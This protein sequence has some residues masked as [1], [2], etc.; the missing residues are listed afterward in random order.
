[1]SASNRDGRAEKKVRA[2]VAL[3]TPPLWEERLAAL[4]TELKAKL[5]GAAFRW[6]HPKQLH[7][8]LRFFGW[9]T[10]DETEQIKQLLPKFCARRTF[11]LVSDGIGCF[12]K[13]RRP[14]VLWAGLSGELAAAVEL[15]AALTDG[16]RSFGEPPEVRPFK[17][18]LTL[19]RLREMPRSDLANVE[20]A[21]RRGFRIESPW[22]VEELLLMQSHLSAQGSCYEVI[23]R[24]AL[25]E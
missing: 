4:Q 13:A 19:A 9:I 24:C 3:K 23:E 22:R 12:P 25:G 7:I 21:I 10:S 18:H 8:T 20:E 2:F 17:P 14:R 15:Q 1:M 11:E 16:T 5:K 6:V